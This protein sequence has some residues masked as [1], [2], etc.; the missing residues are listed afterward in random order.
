[1]NEL[2]L[3]GKV[4]RAY[5]NDDKQLVVVISVMH[6]HVVNNANIRFNSVFRCF[7]NDQSKIASCPVQKDDQIEVIGHLK[8]DYRISRTGQERKAVNIYADDIRITK[9]KNSDLK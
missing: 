5:I 7:M 8:L 3:T 2:K 6:D 1:M 9:Q 4:V